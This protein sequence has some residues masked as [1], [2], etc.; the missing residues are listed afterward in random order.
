MLPVF[1]EAAICVGGLT[2]AWLAIFTSALAMTFA[3]NGVEALLLAVF[4]SVTPGVVTAIELLNVKSW[5]LG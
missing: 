2:N 5:A 3:E 1:W 4:G